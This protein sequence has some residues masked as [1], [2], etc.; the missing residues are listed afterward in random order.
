[1]SLFSELK[2]KIRQ[3]SSSPPINCRHFGLSSKLVINIVQK[4]PSFLLAKQNKRQKPKSVVGAQ[5]QFI[6]YNSIHNE[7][8]SVKLKGN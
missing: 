7:D 8:V 4:P 1:M 6:I 2:K 3:I 5:M